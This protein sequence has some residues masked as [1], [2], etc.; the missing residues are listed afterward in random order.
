MLRSILP[1]NQQNPNTLKKKTQLDNPNPNKEANHEFRG[2]DDKRLIE[3]NP[4]QGGLSQHS[5]NSKRGSAAVT[6]RK[7][8]V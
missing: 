4:K 1:T 8:L 2:R 5:P 6:D 7:F 3:K